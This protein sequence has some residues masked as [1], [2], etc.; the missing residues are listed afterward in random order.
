[1]DSDIVNFFGVMM[2][3]LTVGLLGYGGVVVI[4][5]F[6]SRLKRRDQVSSL[7]P[8]E[9]EALRVQLDEVERLKTRMV[10]LEERVDF[11][12]RLLAQSPDA[13]KLPG[14]SS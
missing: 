10:E 11:A 14:S 3:L 8:D 13:S 5:G 9:V 6:Q 2:S 12:E 7:D 4:H 1:M